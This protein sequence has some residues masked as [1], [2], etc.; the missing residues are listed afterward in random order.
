MNRLRLCS[1]LLALALLAPLAAVA[2]PPLT[3]DALPL[4]GLWPSFGP[5]QKTPAGAQ[6][7]SKLP[8]QAPP[9]LLDRLPRVAAHGY[10]AALRTAQERGP[11]GAADARWIQLFYG[12][13][14]AQAAA[15]SALLRPA[16][17]A[18]WAFLQ[19][20]SAYIQGHDLQMLR[21]ALRLTRLAPDDPA[22]ELA[23]RTLSGQLENEGRTL[24]DAVP[25][26]QRLLSEPL[27]DPT[28]PYMLGRSLLAA[29][30]APGIELTQPGAM[31]LA[32][33]LAHWQLWGPFG[34]WQNL[35]YD[36]V[37]AIERG[38]AAAYPSDLG[39]GVSGPST[40]TPQPYEDI[41]QGVD[42]PVDWAAQ[43]VD[44]ATTYVHVSAPVAVL[45]RLYSPASSALEINGK[46]VLRRDRRSRYDTAVATGAVRLQPG[47]NRVV[48]KLAGEAD[49]EF[50]LMLRPAEG[51]AA[52]VRA[53]FTDAATLPAG[54]SLGA[55]PQL[56]P[57]PPTLASWGAAR[58][59]RDPNDPVA[60]WVDGIRRLQDEDAAHAEVEL[61]RAVRLAPRATA[62]W[63]NLSEA[64]GNLP[65]ASES[66]E[67][68]H[69]E[70]AARAALKASPRALRA[71]D[72][73]GHVYASQGKSTQAAQQ[74]AHCVDKGYADCDWSAF[75]LAVA[76]HWY[77][78]AQTDLGHALAESGSDWPSVASG[79][80]FYAS[81]GIA[82][83]L[84]R[85]Q[86]VLA[87]DPRAAGVYGSY[88]LEHGHPRQAVALLKT[89]MGFDPSATGLR[90]DYLVALQQ[91][92]P[93]AAA[94]AAARQAVR[95]F[96]YDWR[97]ADAAD[98]IELRQDP[99][100]GIAA[101]RRTA[102]NRNLL[103]HQA[104]YLAGDKFW[105]PWYHSEAEILAHPPGT[106]QYPNASSIL[107]FDQMVDRIN[108][109]SSQD[110]YI[111]QIY[112]VLNATGI[113]QLGDVT[114]IPPGSDLI[115]IRTI[116]QDG[117]ML[118]PD[119]ITNIQDISMPGLEAGDY[120]EIE[121]V[122]HMAPSPIIPGS[123]DNSE[124]F[125]FNSSTQPYN[126]S[127]YIVLSPPGYPLLVDSERFPNPSTVRTL[128]DGYRAQQWL[129]QKTRMLIT[130]PN[131]PSEEHLVPKVWVSS[132][133]TWDEMSDYFA[134]H[135]FAVRRVTP[136]MQREADQL[137]AGKTTPIARANAIFSWVAANI[138]PG[139]GT[140]LSPARQFF[141]D[142]NGNR[143]AT[144]LALLSAAKVPYQLVLARLVT[145]DS[146]TKIPSVY[147]FQ[148]PL[149]HV[150]D[151]GPN[152]PAGWYDLNN[153]FAQLNY[154]S[155]AVRGGLALVAGA[156]GAAAFTHVP[157]FDSP[158]D[159]MVVSVNAQVAP[160]GD[161]TLR[162]EMDFR[163]P[164][165]E[166][167]RKELANLPDSGLPQ[168]Y[169]QVLLA[170][171]PNA[172]PTGGRIENRHSKSK[173]LVFVIHATVPS[174]VT[175]DGAAAGSNWDIE[176]LTGAVGVL[177]R[178]APLP[179][180]QHPLIIPG[181]SFERTTVTLSLPPRFGS[182]A[183]PAATS[184]SNNFGRF[185]SS[186]TQNGGQIVFHRLL[187]LK[188]NLI[189]PDAYPEF[190][191]FARAIDAQ[192]HLR[193]TGKVGGE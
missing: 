71:Y 45:L 32:G 118:L 146:S 22:T 168:V 175:S 73:L 140:I 142:R 191:A 116:K 20:L 28:T 89:A 7:V 10:A 67:A 141:T 156:Q 84:A 188:A 2:R 109:D 31:A 154:L 1:P 100:Q 108:P 187:F 179:F 169:Q 171:Y 11:A 139:A 164:A 193:L 162:L 115:T 114:T 72:R 57:A 149:V 42:F 135:M 19:F 43:G 87:A 95:D 105:A 174:F 56:L 101:L 55:A 12:P 23:V 53:G 131:M 4:V 97:V 151:A 163:G 113:S 68:S 88:Q 30:H 186:Y 93:P 83:P 60:L 39:A 25:T 155:P 70:Q 130:E 77:S 46:L 75:H 190:R 147:Q 41:G 117:R 107:V 90:R 106:T 96:P 160:S 176:H 183:L 170:S 132:A 119:K 81:L 138:Q 74:F 145:D 78:E 26:L 152:S 192:D 3:R 86:R 69:M 121:F 80:Q 125:V 76:Q 62:I 127:D 16:P 65:D 182:P 35:G 150:G 47:W 54:A 51:P 136:D 129:V 178:Y 34:E 58:L 48:V 181:D 15:E 172:T 17:G 133:L 63:L 94:L 134:D 184:L 104:D 165:G 180:R 82:Q 122:Q 50:D 64:Y 148:Y 49:R 37:F 177:R 166:E 36:H 98:Q 66:W 126:Y 38:I 153:D 79:L 128:P 124:F 137:A 27:R 13:P 59:A 123:L 143:V 52:G 189:Q 161:A 111:H 21:A 85:W 24:L 185:T 6:G 5:R 167:V 144:F 91:A 102:F 99:A 14:E 9:S 61:R 33:R 18:E 92:G 120:I 112:R 158:L 159:G 40:R 103:R 29:V 44:F 110:Q 173:P 8:R 157:A